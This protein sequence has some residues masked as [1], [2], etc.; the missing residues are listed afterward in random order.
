ML[1]TEKGLL[2]S[3]GPFEKGKCP[4]DTVL[5]DRSHR[6]KVKPFQTPVLPARKEK[7]S[8]RLVVNGG[9][10][11]V[12]ALA[13]TVYGLVET[14]SS[15]DEEKGNGPAGSVQPAEKG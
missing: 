13:D 14:F 10:G 6:W 7:T 1:Y 11:L 3:L 9:V 5:E 2:A 4:P 15:S 12:H 8:R